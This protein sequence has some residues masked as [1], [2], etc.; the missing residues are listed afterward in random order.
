MFS[1][2]KTKILHSLLD[3]FNF[4]RL[5]IDSHNLG[6][7]DEYVADLAD[8]VVDHIPETLFV[9]PHRRKVW[10]GLDHSDKLLVGVGFLRELGHLDHK[11][12]EN[13]FL[14]LVV[15][16]EELVDVAYYL[17]IFFLV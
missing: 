1:T 15:D 8:R 3:V 17:I 16:V 2:P 6:S 9:N 12:R 10:I 14:T 11:G 7:V 5:A 4:G 13:L